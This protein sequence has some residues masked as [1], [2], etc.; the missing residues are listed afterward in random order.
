MLFL[1]QVVLPDDE[2]MAKIMAFH[3]HNDFFF[4][5]P[6]LVP[7]KQISAIYLKVRSDR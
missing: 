3:E 7:L 5:H 4:V 6:G 1:S 2:R